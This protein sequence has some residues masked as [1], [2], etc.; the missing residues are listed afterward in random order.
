MWGG[1][2]EDVNENFRLGNIDTC[3][4][5]NEQRDFQVKVNNT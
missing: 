2:I 5:M 4:K 3:A 1:G